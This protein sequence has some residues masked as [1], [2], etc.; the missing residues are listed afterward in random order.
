M[1]LFNIAYI[2]MYFNAP[3]T[4]HFYLSLTKTKTRWWHLFLIYLPTVILTSAQFF[5][6]SMIKDIIKYKGEWTVVL[7]SQSFWV[8]VNILTIL[9]AFIVSYIV[10][11]QWGKTT[12]LKK[13]KIYSRIIQ[14]MLPITYFS[15]LLFTLIL[16]MFGLM[17][18]QGIGVIFYN[19]NLAVLYYMVSKLQFLNLNYSILAD[20]IISNFKAMVILL[21]SDL[22]IVSVNAVFKDIFQITD[23]KIL[24]RS[25]LDLIKD[26]RETRK[27]IEEIQAKKIQDLSLPIAYKKG[28]EWIETKSYIS[29]IKDKFGDFSGFFVISNEE[30]E[31]AQFQKRFKI[32][33]REMEIIGL[34]ISGSTY[35]DV[36]GKL[37]ISE[38]TV[39][40]HLTHIYN[41]LG[42]NN[43]MELVRLAGEFNIKA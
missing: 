41:K 24:N 37:F 13:E 15:V 2:G 3:T 5:G 30:K 35:K 42:I 19:I 10:V 12:V 16:P 36:S 7:N 39:E 29:A 27:K 33:G 34:I 38:K 6:Y 32:T 18:L 40:T 21:D 8:Y 31:T 43:K 28:G 20:E 17:E 23:N 26:N 25:Y 14:I 22:K 9:A 11:S 4:I 1:L